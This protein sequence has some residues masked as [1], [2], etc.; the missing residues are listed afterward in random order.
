MY[1]FVSWAY[2]EVAEEADAARKLQ[3]NQAKKSKSAE[4]KAIVETLTQE[5]CLPEYAEYV[6]M[7][8]QSDKMPSE[9]DMDMIN[10]NL[11][12]VRFVIPALGKTVTYQLSRRAPALPSSEG[13]LPVSLAARAFLLTTFQGEWSGDLQ[14][15]G[16]NRVIFVGLPGIK[17]FLQQ[18]AMCCGALGQPLPVDL[19][20]NSKQYELLPEFELREMIE[21][22]A[23]YQ[24][25]KEDAQQYRDLTASWCG[26]AAS[27]ER[28][29]TLLLTASFKLGFK[30]V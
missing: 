7:L 19:Y 8:K 10:R 27:A 20:T 24:E 13:R 17:K 18:L 3:V 29:S 9:L 21:A 2:T 5:H 22:C 11:L 15:P 28:D 30:G 12:A 4:D 26:I 23:F 1:V 6:N 25:A 14:A 16:P